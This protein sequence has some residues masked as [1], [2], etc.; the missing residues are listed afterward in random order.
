MDGRPIM[1]LEGGEF[2]YA[3][4]R[5]NWLMSELNPQCYSLFLPPLLTLVIAAGFTI[6]FR[7]CAAFFYI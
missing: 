6:F 5:L 2:E 1:D 4:T 3:W 7:E